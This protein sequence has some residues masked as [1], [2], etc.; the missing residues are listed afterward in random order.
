[1]QVR[2]GMPNSKPVFNAVARARARGAKAQNGQR[3]FGG[4]E[5]D[6]Y[7]NIV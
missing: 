5:H 7:S 2:Y 6:C 4:G 3:G 1:M